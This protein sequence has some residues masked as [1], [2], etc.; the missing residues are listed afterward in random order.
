MLYANDHQGRWPVTLDAL[1]VK[2]DITPGCF[3]CP[4]SSD[5]PAPGATPQ[6]QAGNLYNGGHL[7]FVY[8]GKGLREPVHPDR[9]VAY[10]VPGHHEG[11]GMNV[12]F[13]D[14]HV[15]WF[16]E[17]KA[18]EILADLGAGWNPPKMFVPVSQRAVTS[19]PAR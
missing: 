3:V 8:L 2:A 12:M 15:E 6:E 16:E 14:G 11:A 7:S 17:P 18:K 4:S 19:R 1:I 10:E 13:G 9:V 5:S